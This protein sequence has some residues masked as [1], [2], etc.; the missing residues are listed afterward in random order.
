MIRL[1]C[2]SATLVPF[3]V[4][5]IQM[6]VADVWCIVLC[7]SDA[8]VWCLADQSHSSLLVY[9]RKPFSVHCLSLCFAL[10]LSVNMRA[11][12]PL[13]HGLTHTERTLCQSG[14]KWSRESFLSYLWIV[15]GA[16]WNWPA[17]VIHKHSAFMLTILFRVCVC[18]IERE[19][20]ASFG[21]CDFNNV[22][23]L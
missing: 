2:G 1:C 17:W 23:C 20:R 14:C 7:L 19:S 13:A 4:I 21:S 3:C 18:M 10:I 11:R 8:T 22:K 16:Q 12:L 6:C 9:Q 5:V 15:L